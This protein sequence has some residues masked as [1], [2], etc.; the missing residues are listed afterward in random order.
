M[1][2]DFSKDLGS[3]PLKSKSGT[4]N[5]ADVVAENDVIGL[6]FSAHWC[7]PCRGFTPKLCEWYTNK[8]GEGKKIEIIFVSSDRDE[9]SF[10]GYLGEMAD[11]LALSFSERD[12][13]SKVSTQFG[14][15]GIP[16][17]ILFDA[18]TGKMHTKDGR[19]AVMNNKFDW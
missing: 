8:K 18:K 4:K 3:A 2:I 13:K 10:N 1:S 19:A 16:T 15:Q 12:T 11:W 14:V 7:P 6:Y 5:I 17:F 9:D